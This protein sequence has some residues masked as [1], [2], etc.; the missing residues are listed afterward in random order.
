MHQF[1]FCSAAAKKAARPER[2]AASTK[3]TAM[4]GGFVAASSSRD[5]RDEEADFA[6]KNPL[7]EFN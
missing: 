6:R 2:R 4:D 3:A 7:P 5:L 1:E